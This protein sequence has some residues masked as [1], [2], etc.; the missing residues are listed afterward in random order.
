MT[1]KTAGTFGRAVAAPESSPSTT[2]APLAKDRSAARIAIQQRREEA[3]RAVQAE[4]EFEPEPDPGPPS[5]TISGGWGSTRKSQ[6]LRPLTELQSVEEDINTPQQQ[7]DFYVRRG[8]LNLH[9]QYWLKATIDAD[10]ALLVQPT[11]VV[12]WELLAEGQFLQGDAGKCAE[13]CKRALE[14][15]GERASMAAREQKVVDKIQR[16]QTLATEKATEVE[17]VK[18]SRDKVGGIRRN[19]RVGKELCEVV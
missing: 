7:V 5:R 9:Q 13:T 19:W 16:M 11:S 10:M 6:E 12:A 14:A 15:C 8:R 4:D 2:R 3:A 1:G 18:L 17:A